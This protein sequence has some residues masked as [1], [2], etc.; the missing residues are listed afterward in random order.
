MLFFPLVMPYLQ[1]RQNLRELSRQPITRFRIKAGTPR[2][3]TCKNPRIV[4]AQKT[5]TV[6]DAVQIGYQT[7]KSRNKVDQER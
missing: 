2:I 4:T 5:A 7:P 1:L 6:S 3:A